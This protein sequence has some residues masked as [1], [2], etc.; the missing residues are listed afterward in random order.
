MWTWIVFGYLS[1]SLAS[2]TKV[3][4]LGCYIFEAKSDEL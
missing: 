3:S 4:E 1:L 2:L